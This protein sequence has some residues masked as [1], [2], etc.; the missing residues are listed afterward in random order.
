MDETN[1]E[2]KYSKTLPQ[3]SI[4]TPSYNQ[5]DFVER[6]I[7]SVICQDYPNL[8]YVFVDAVSVDKTQEILEKYKPH[9][10]KLIVEPDK[11]QTEALNKGFRHCT[12]EI[13]AYLNSDDCYADKDVIATIVQQFQDHP[14]IDV[15]YG[16]R[17]CIN[18]MG[19]FGYCPPFRAFCEKS[20]YLSDYIAQECVF[21]RRGIFE[22]TGGY[23]DESFQFAMD[24]E[25]WLRFLKH[26]AKFLSI[27]PFVGL[28]RSYEDQKSIARWES[29]GLPE[30]A[31]LHEAYLGRILPEKEMVDHYEEYFFG[32]HPKVSPAAFKMA[33]HLWGHYMIHKKEVLNKVPLDRWGF[34]EY[35]R[36]FANRSL[37]SSLQEAASA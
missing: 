13:L 27:E 37:A 29:V 10:A 32:V 15:I 7:L 21:W 35:D 34:A 24:Y 31:R 36:K 2:M 1:P 19:R 8:Q 33:Q 17:N 11:G 12:G 28:F 23:L 6:T 4:V 20:L 30:I 16:Q 5:G 22:K 3:V 9:F 25:L 18:K 14:E 26:G